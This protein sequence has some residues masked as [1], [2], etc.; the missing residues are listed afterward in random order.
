MGM[1]C[2]LWATAALTGWITLQPLPRLT[3]LTVA[4]GTV[5]ITGTGWMREAGSRHREALA[6]FLFEA[7]GLAH[8]FR[9]L[10]GASEGSITL[11]TGAEGSAVW[12]SDRGKPVLASGVVEGSAVGDSKLSPPGAPGGGTPGTVCTTAAGWIT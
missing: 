7:L 3:T 5:K 12:G 9:N 11:G 6:P 10:D 2:G 1:A 4:A 8:G